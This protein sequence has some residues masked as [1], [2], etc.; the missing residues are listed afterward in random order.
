MGFPEWLNWTELGF[1]DGSA[2]NNL[3]ANAEVLGLIPGLGRPPGVGKATHTSIL[4]WKIPWT[5]E[6]ARLQFTESQSQTWQQLSTHHWLTVSQCIPLKGIWNQHLAVAEKLLKLREKKRNKQV[7][8]LITVHTWLETGDEI[9]NWSQG[10][11]Y[12]IFPLHSLVNNLIL[13]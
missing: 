2:V 4:D 13:R 7:C 11:Y 6:P 9:N 5:E 12:G 10:G 3:P 8:S 1:S